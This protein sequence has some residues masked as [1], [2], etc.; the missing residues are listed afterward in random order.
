MPEPS[1]SYVFGEFRLDPEGGWLRQGEQE[2]ELPPKAFQVLG[3]LIERRERLVPKQELME[4]L[5]KDTF[6][7]DDA[8]VQSIAAIRRALGDDPERPRYIRTKPRVGY[9]FIAPVEAGAAAA[10]VPASVA[11]TR[12][13]TARALF[14]V[15]QAGY[16]TLYA[17]TLYYAEVAAQVV[18]RGLAGL[19]GGALLV[20]VFL[21]LAG[22]AVRLY[23]VAVVAF[24]HPQTA[25][26]FRRLFPVLLVLDVVWALSPLLLAEKTGL[27]LALALVPV[28]AYGPFSQRT[29]VRSAYTVAGVR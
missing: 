7:T 4:A 18:A 11:P 17:V 2:V 14:L 28:L 9:Q 20:V 29:L 19:G 25:A 22:I 24:D 16:L 15:I 1:R 13:G 10:V 26:K 23:L 27:L 3:Y 21:A 12:R 8:L 6:V 5:W